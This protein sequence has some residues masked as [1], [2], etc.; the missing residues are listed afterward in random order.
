MGWA[1]QGYRAL[2]ALSAPLWRLQLARRVRRGKEDP[3]RLP[4]RMG[5]ASVA[6]P[7]GHLLWVHALGIGEAAAMLAVI[8]E[9]QRLRP[10]VAVLLTTNTRTGAEGLVRMGLPDGVIHQYAPV[11]TPGAV[12]RF[13]DHWRPDALLL[14]ELD[15]WPLML[16]RLAARGVPVVMANARLTD[17]RMAD[18]QRMRAL[19]A[20]VLGLIG[21]KLVQDDR[22]RV[23]LIALGADPASVAVAGLLK[24]AAAP[25]P[26]SPDRPAVAKALAGRPVWLA[27][28]T[29]ARELPALIAAHRLALTGLPGLLLIIAPRQP[30][31]ADA[32][33]ATLAAAFGRPPPRRSRGAIPGPLDPVWLADTMGEMGLWY[34]IAPLAFVG[35][36]LGVEGPPPLTGK[37]PFEAAALGAVVLHGPCTGNFAESYAALADAV[38]PVDGAEALGR[39][40][41]DLTADAAARARM[42]AAATA[43]LEQARGALPMTV[44]AVLDRLPPAHATAARIDALTVRA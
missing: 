28:A 17:R 20:D 44:Q 13:L 22:T 25:L 23:R 21:L 43:V 24:A 39:A 19:M 37:N 4:E 31:D 30:K 6:R 40:V 42:A 15:L 14:A 7:G 32:A 11:D 2:A 41:L 18:R 36:S 1:L 38:R 35:H 27:A 33:A 9:V 29:E 26:D 12:R 10:D 5:H 8:R 16:S 3:A 34:R